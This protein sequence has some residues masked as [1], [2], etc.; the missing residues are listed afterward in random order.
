MFLWKIIQEIKIFI[1]TAKTN[2]TS[3]PW[4]DNNGNDGAGYADK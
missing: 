2:V 1:G 3:K 4:Q